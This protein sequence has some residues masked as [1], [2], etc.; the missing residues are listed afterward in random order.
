[1]FN[2]DGLGILIALLAILAGLRLAFYVVERLF[3]RH[4]D[5]STRVA[6][7]PDESPEQQESP[8]VPPAPRRYQ[9]W[10]EV[11]DSAII[12]VALVAFLIRPFL[13]QSF[14]IPSGSMNNTL[15]KGDMLIASKITYRL[16]D[17]HRGDVVVFHAPETALRTLG[18]VYDPKHPTEYVKRVIGVPGDRISIVAGEGVYVNGKHLSE[19]YVRSQV[20]YY[21]PTTPNGDLAVH[22][23]EVRN[24][25]IPAVHGRDL[26]V[27]KGYLFM[28]GDNRTQ[29]HDG[30]AWGLL[31]RDRVVGEAAFIFWP[32]PR[33]GIIR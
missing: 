19:P 1:M 4:D 12:A 8:A 9:A 20:D 28:L 5:T 17:P 23:A 2:T 24:Q 13:V 15:I 6:L 27:P 31:R 29:S 11:L 18:Q 26:V 21:F 32:V 30:H 3:A 16:H 25:L 33:I 14:I 10:Y 7:L 22:D